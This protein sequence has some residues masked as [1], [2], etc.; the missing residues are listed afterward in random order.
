MMRSVFAIPLALSMVAAGCA[1]NPD[2]DEDLLSNEFEA[3]IGT[4]PESSDT[5]GDGYSD[6]YEHFTYFSPLRANDVPY[7]EEGADYHRMPLLFGDDWDEVSDGAG[8]DE[9]D[10][11]R[12]WTATDQ[13]GIDLKLK[14]FYGQVILID[15]SAEWCNPCRGAAANL[16]EEYEQ[17]RDDGFVAFTVLT[18]D[19]E[20]E[21]APSADRWSDDFGIHAPIIEDGARDIADRYLTT[22]YP[23]YTILDRNHEIVSLDAQGGEADFDLID[24]LLAE[25]PPDVSYLWPE[26]VAEIAE[27]LGVPVPTQ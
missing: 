1:T 24:D 3:L 12:S 20:G 15:V 17:R 9:G 10:F 11:S 14:R 7:E 18:E 21:P 26:G 16:Q 23:T 27:A 25:D 4:D 19:P 5:D 2:I 22:A 8:W 13:F 6:A